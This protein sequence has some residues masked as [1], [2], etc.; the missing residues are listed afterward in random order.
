MA[1][2]S[3]TTP[4]FGVVI[5]ALV[6]HEPITWSLGASTLLVAGGIGLASLRSEPAP[7]RPIPAPAVARPGS[8]P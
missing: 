5:T 7:A 4:V 3:L 8:A 6:L 2:L 1:V